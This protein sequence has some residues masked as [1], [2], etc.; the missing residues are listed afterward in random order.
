MVAGVGKVRAVEH[1]HTSDEPVTSVTERAAR[2]LLTVEALLLGHSV[3]LA[4][5]MRISSRCSPV[6]RL[7]VGRRAAATA[8]LVE[9]VD[10]D[11][12]DED[13]PPMLPGVEVDDALVGVPPNCQPHPRCEHC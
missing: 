6:P 8:A 7:E 2:T 13:A 4:E 11:D 1:A 12:V 5:M 9:Y 3:E 10:V